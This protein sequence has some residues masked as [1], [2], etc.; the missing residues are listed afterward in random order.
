MKEIIPFEA[1]EQRI[2]FIRGHKVMLD[3]HLAELYNV[4]TFRLNE[5]VKRNIDRFPE[6]FMFQL[7][8]QEWENL[9]SQFAISSWGG[10]RTLPYVFTE[11][12]ALMLAS[13]LNSEIAIKASIQVVR[14]FTKLRELLSS[15][16]ELAAKIN[17]LEKKYDKQFQVVFEAIKQLIAKKNEPRKPIGFKIKEK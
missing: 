3:S 7:N 11:H 6:D 1:I 17:E 10:R 2:L 13:V 8:T 5:K 14:T 12:G 9:K 16:K 4:E 15:N